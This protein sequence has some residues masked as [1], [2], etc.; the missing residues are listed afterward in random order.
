[1]K[2]VVTSGAAEKMV[3]PGWMAATTTEPEPVTVRR[4]PEIVA[5]PDLI[6]RLTGS[7]DVE[8]GT[9]KVR[10]GAP[11]GRFGILG[12][13]EIF[14]PSGRILNETICSR[15][16]E[17]EALPGWLTAR[18]TIPA[19]LGVTRLPETVAGPDLT[20]KVTGN[21]EEAFGRDTG[22]GVEE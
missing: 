9:L 21:P 19:P 12:M 8:V 13:A 11:T 5:G 1:M 4:L 15:A 7:P 6:L 18:T 10:S 3:F 14:C 20:L 2:E 17:N 22:T 16:G